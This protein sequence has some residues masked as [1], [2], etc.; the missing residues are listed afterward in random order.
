MA[1]RNVKLSLPEEDADRLWETGA[2]AGMT[3]DQVL[4][5]FFGD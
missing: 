4:Q 5:Y 2:R 3:P 1:E